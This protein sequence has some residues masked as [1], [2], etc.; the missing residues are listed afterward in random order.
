ME[1][2]LK[3]SNARLERLQGEHVTEKEAKRVLSEEVAILKAKNASLELNQYKPHNHN[4]P[5]C[6][7]TLNVT[8]RGVNPVAAPFFPGPTGASTN[9]SFTQFQ[10]MQAHEFYQA[11]QFR[12]QQLNMQ[13]FLH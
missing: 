2:K 8:D 9:M 11:Q 10:L 7:N 12:S 1:R 13:M 4:T 6:T 3:L 5:T